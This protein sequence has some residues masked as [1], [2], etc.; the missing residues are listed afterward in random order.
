MYNALIIRCLERP[1]YSR[2]S[3]NLLYWFIIIYAYLS[4][5]VRFMIILWK[6][7]ESRKAVYSGA[8]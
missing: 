3:N 5:Y 7:R 1:K 4:V 6:D 2:D 8:D